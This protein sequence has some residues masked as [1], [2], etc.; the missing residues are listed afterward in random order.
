MR[1]NELKKVYHSEKRSLQHKNKIGTVLGSAKKK[2]KQLRR[3]SE[4][5][6]VYVCFGLCVSLACLVGWGARF[7]CCMAT[8][9]PKNF[10]CSPKFKILTIY[11]CYTYI[12]MMDIGIVSVS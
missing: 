11:V 7:V 3:I 8:R 10:F 9:L 4:S 1:N 12:L 6:V 2:F 5:F